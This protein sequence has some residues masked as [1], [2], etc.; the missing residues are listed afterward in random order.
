MS[1][2]QLQIAFVPSVAPWFQ[3]IISTVS[4]PLENEMRA[5]DVRRLFEERYAAEPLVKVQK[6][7]PEIKDIAGQHGFR[8]GGF[9]MHSSGKRV[10]VVVARFISF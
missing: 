9:Q 1:D 2:R 10:V 8:A 4:V 7:V 6:T 3:G 5:E